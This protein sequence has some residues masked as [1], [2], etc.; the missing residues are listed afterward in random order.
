MV[1]VQKID[2]K[3]WSKV[4]IMI[5]QSSFIWATCSKILLVR[6]CDVDS[7]ACFVCWWNF[8][9]AG[10]V[11]PLLH[12]RHLIY[13]KVEEK[14]HEKDKKQALHTKKMSQNEQNVKH[15]NV[16]FLSWYFSWNFKALAWVNPFLQGIHLKR[17][18]PLL[19]CSSLWDFKPDA[20]ENAFSQV[21]QMKGSP[22]SEL[23]GALSKCPSGWKT[24]HIRHIWMASHLGEIECVCSD[25]LG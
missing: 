16:F 10:C 14:K 8:R 18:S 9:D 6:F 22:Q 25:Q 21:G 1:K 5:F 19:L 12:A 17:F 20:C 15:L 23:L 7:K 3:S 13:T 11:K 24:L 4:L 2:R